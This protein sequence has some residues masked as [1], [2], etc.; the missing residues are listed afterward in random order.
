MVNELDE[1]GN[2]NKGMDGCEYLGSN[3]EFCDKSLIAMSCC[4][5]TCENCR[6]G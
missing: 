4:L 6:N 5:K 3:C 1:E 2:L